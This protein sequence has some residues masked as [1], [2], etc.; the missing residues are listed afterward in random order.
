[1]TQPR[2]H[3]RAQLAVAREEFSSP[4][5]WST[6]QDA[7]LR[8]HRQ[9]QLFAARGVVRQLAEWPSVHE[10][11]GLVDFGHVLVRE[12]VEEQRLSRNVDRRRDLAELQDPGL[13]VAVS[14]RDIESAENECSRAVDA[15]RSVGEF[16]PHNAAD[17][18][19]PNRKHARR[20]EALEHEIRGI[21]ARRRL[22]RLPSAIGN[23]DLFVALIA[24][25]LKERPSINGA[26]PPHI[27]PRADDREVQE[28]GLLAIGGEHHGARSH[29]RL[30]APKAAQPTER[31]LARFGKAAVGRQAIKEQ[32]KRRAIARVELDHRLEAPRRIRHRLHERRLRACAFEGRSDDAQRLG[33]GHQRRRLHRIGRGRHAR[34]LP[35]ETLVDLKE[36]RGLLRLLDVERDRL[37]CSDNRI[38]HR[39]DRLGACLVERGGLLRRMCDGRGCHSGNSSR[40][41]TRRRTPVSATMGTHPS[42]K[43]SRTCRDRRRH[44]RG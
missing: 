1:M 7:H 16:M 43:E 20:R 18:G 42:P 39:R 17:F 22:D 13:R 32:P 27:V 36:P 25:E 6:A 29:A 15:H 11:L 19:T 8:P 30:K 24:A 37:V 38:A 3:E 44:R 41:I 34:D 4:A 14:T 2:A 28:F 21:L 35:R 33:T 23:G 10:H 12:D 5:R 40:V 26:Q 9:S 31:E